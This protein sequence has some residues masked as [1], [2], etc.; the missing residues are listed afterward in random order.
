MAWT[1]YC[2]DEQITLSA[3]TKEELTQKVMEHMQESHDTTI[4][5]DQARENVEKNAKQSAA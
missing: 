1:Y 2:E 3:L 5:M 4:S